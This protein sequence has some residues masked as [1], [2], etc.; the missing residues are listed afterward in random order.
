M[1]PVK[2]DSVFLQ[3]INNAVPLGQAY[4]GDGGVLLADSEVYDWTYTLNSSAPLLYTRD[5]ILAKGDEFGGKVRVG[6]S[7]DCESP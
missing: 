7:T 6:E 3:A 1:T 2:A 4:Q 5:D